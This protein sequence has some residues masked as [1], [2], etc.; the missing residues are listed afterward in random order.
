[1]GLFSGRSIDHLDK[2]EDITTTIK[3]DSDAG[4]ISDPVNGEAGKQGG[5]ALCKNQGLGQGQ[6]RGGACEQDTHSMTHVPHSR[7]AT[8]GPD[9][10]S[11]LPKTEWPNDALETSGILTSQHQD[12]ASVAGLAGVGQ[13]DSNCQSILSIAG[14]AGSTP[15]PGS[16]SSSG[17]TSPATYGYRQATRSLGPP[18]PPVAANSLPSGC[19][20]TEAPIPLSSGLASQEPFRVTDMTAHMTDATTTRQPIGEKVA[21][22]GDRRDG[23]VTVGGADAAGGEGMATVEQSA[24]GLNFFW[25]NEH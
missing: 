3:P 20:S 8:A 11:V 23:A 18:S 15:L 21:H 2:S 25:P 13:I 12:L 17:S 4:T 1:M 9:Q 5:C 14:L 22:W 10:S 24:F 16:L 6:D 19:Y 7:S